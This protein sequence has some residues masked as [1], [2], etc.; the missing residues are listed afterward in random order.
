VIFGFELTLSSLIRS[1]ISSF[2]AESNNFSFSSWVYKPVLCSINLEYW[3]STYLF[4]LYYRK[5]QK[6]FLSIY[7]SCTSTFCSGSRY[8]VETFFLENTIIPEHPA[9]RPTTDHC[10]W[11]WRLNL[12]R[13]R[14]PT[15]SRIWWKNLRS[16][17]K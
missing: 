11:M 17:T 9:G 16:N 10:A 7:L 13:H 8:R 2:F 14:R 12:D 4:E 15:I 6:L 5:L 1:F 3:T